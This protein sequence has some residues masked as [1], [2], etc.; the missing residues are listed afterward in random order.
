[1]LRKGFGGA[2]WEKPR[3][4]GQTPGFY[5]FSCPVAFSKL[6]IPVSRELRVW[7]SVWGVMDS[8]NGIQYYYSKARRYYNNYNDFF[9]YYFQSQNESFGLSA[10]LLMIFRLG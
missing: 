6:R 10:T 4:R 7:K 1:M 8:A 5:L 2:K 3:L 9:N